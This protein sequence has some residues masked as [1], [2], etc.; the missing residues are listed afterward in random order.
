M[1]TAFGPLRSGRSA[2]HTG[3]VEFVLRRGNIIHKF[4]AV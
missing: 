4:A 3:L 1:A 2:G